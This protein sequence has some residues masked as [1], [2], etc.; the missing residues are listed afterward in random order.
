[1]HNAF[2]VR[3]SFIIKMDRVGLKFFMSVKLG[4]FEK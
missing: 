2:F 3:F 4:F 1:M